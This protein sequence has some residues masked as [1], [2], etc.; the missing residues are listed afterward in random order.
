[1]KIS[2]LQLSVIAPSHGPI[3]DDPAVIVQPYARW[4]EGDTERKVLIVYVS[5]W[6]STA[7]LVRHLV[8]QLSA[9]GVAGAIAEKI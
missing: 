4:S 7:G 3:Y 6:G 5:M 9:R 1:M 2:E 8:E